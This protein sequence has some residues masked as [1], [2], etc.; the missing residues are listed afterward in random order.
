MTM[1]E[2]KAILLQKVKPCVLGEWGEAIDMAI[3]VLS[4]E[5]HEIRTETHGVCSDLISRAE[6]LDIIAFKRKLA[7]IDG[8][9]LLDETVDRIKALPSAEQVTGKLN[10]PCDS[11]LKADSESCK[12]QKSKLD[13]ISRADAIEAVKEEIRFYEETTKDQQEEFDEG[14][15]C[16]MHRAKTRIR[17]LPSA[18]KPTELLDDGTL[19]V[20]VKSGAKVNRVLVW[21][22]DGSGGLY[23]ADDR[24]SGEWED[25]EVFSETNDDHIVDEWQSARCSICG[26]YHTTP[27][28]YYF[29]SFNYC[30]NCG[31]KMGGEAK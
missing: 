7:N 1:E 4:A 19:K 5:T 3:E 8:R 28:M 31:A 13:L 24:P 20:N 25:K 11:L 9:I 15:I 6:V 10:N 22:D 12:E 18:D 30:P 26:K 29:D 16:G 17:E 27:Y 23:Y 21:G 2:A 14:F